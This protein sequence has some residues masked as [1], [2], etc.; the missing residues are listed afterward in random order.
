MIVYRSVSWGWICAL[1]RSLT[2]FVNS[3]NLQFKTLD[4]S[5]INIWVHLLSSSISLRKSLLEHSKF[6]FELLVRVILNRTLLEALIFFLILVLDRLNL[7]FLLLSFFCYDSL[8]FFSFLDLLCSQLSSL[9]PWQLRNL[10]LSIVLL[11]SVYRCWNWFRR[12]LIFSFL[13][14]LF[15]SLLHGL[16]A[17][18]IDEG[19]KVIRVQI[20]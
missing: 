11:L 15:A 16:L 19:N 4:P 18:I 6:L 13:N 5:C 17:T 9:L 2:V 14:L 8:F 10:N 12:S 7:F 20:V 3:L 1:F